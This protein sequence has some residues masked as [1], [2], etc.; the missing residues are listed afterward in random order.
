MSENRIGELIQ[1][2]KG[3]D[4]SL[5]EYARDSGVDAA[6][7]SKIIN[8]VYIPKNKKIYLSLTS[9]KAAPRGGVTFEQMVE[10]ADS[11]KSYKEGVVAGKALTA[12]ALMA[13]A[14]L[15]LM[16]G[17]P[18]FA[19]GALGAGAA[20]F[21]SG[22][23][24]RTK[25][26]EIDEA[27]NDLQRFIAVSD[28]LILGALGAKGI[29]FQIA[30]KRNEV[31]DNQFDKYINL[32][33]KEIKE[34]ILRYAYIPDDQ[35]NAKYVFERIPRTLVEELAF[36]EPSKERKVT[37][38]TNT[39]EAFNKLLYFKNRLSYNGELSIILI[40]LMKAELCRE[41]Y[42]SHFVGV[43]VPSELLLV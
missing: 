32:N 39:V 20:V 34:Y 26:G 5:R 2:A 14:P 35:K 27:I 37:I 19:A 33:D 3:D 24:S 29:P 8:G 25:K 38:V 12:A 17:A 6:I 40:D 43:D 41:E 7:I 42:I 4:R 22:L 13:G 31:L 10:A 28:G 23:F 30:N 9:S 15:A 1:K 21:S 36:L 16:T 18:I 11:S